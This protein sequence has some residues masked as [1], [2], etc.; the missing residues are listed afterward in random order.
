MSFILMGLLVALDRDRQVGTLD[1]SAKAAADYLKDNL[2]LPVWNLGFGEIESQLDTAMLDR[3][4]YGIRLSLLDVAHPPICRTRDEKWKMTRSE[5]IEVAGMIEE[6][7]TI[8]HD[9]NAIASISVYYTDRFVREDMRREAFLLAAIMTAEATTLMLALILALRS[10]VFRPLWA[11]ESWAEGVSRGEAARLPAP[12]SAGGEIESLRSSIGRMVALL[13][14]RYAEI[15][16]QDRELRAALAVK[17]A[18]AQELFHRTRNNVQV[19][20]S[21]IYLR[22][23]RCVDSSEGRDLQAIE[24]SVEAI[25]L[26]QEELYKREDLSCLDFAS[27]LRALA[28]RFV[29]KG[30]GPARWPRIEVEAES[31]IIT[32]DLAIPLGLIATELLANAIEHGFPGG[33][34]GTIKLS[35]ARKPDGRALLRVEDDGV[36]PQPGFDPCRDK[37][38][39]ME[40]VAALIEQVRGRIEY[41]C[42]KGFSC[43]IDFPEERPGVA[44]RI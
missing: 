5:P 32:I 8:S 27:Y 38:L 13:D 14:E 39:G 35:L 7:R 22:K 19:I 11:I 3:T 16:S 20:C 9:G 42:S 18:L 44:R 41:D 40:T 28:D 2:I 10:S 25:A 12:R 30:G 34:H 37:A 15:V 21:L 4:A 36:G 24:A 43:A 6:E 23:A 26:A 33:R 17:E 1:K 29:E 31:L